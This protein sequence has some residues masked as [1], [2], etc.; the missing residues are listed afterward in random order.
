MGVLAALGIRR[1]V[2]IFLA[3]GTLIGG[4]GAVVGCLAGGHRLINSPDGRAG[5]FVC[6]GD[7]EVTA[8]MGD[9]LMPV[10]GRR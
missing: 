4:V 2:I 8:L 3:E 1:Q 10:A 7:G 5:L 6:S 9:H